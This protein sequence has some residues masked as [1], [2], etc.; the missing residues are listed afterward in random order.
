M[1]LRSPPQPVS[2]T[3]FKVA[4]EDVA[5]NQFQDQVI[6]ILNAFMKKQGE[7][8]GAV[9]QYTT[10]SR[11]APSASM[12]GIVI[13]LKDTGAAEVLQVCLSSADGSF[14]WVDIVAGP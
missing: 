6:G 4:G 7:K 2:K 11:P 13:R 14:H 5:F 3:L 8:T 1:A 10:A 9:E 12:D